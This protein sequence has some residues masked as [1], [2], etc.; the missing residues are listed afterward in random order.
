MVIR[1]CGNSF[2]IHLKPLSTKKCIEG[3][4]LSNENYIQALKHLKDRYGNPQLITL[5]HISKLLKLEKVFNRRS[6]K[7]LGNLYDRVENYIRSLLTAGI[8]QENYGPLLI[9]IV[10][11]NLP[12][13]I[14]LVLSRNL[15]TD[16]SKIDKMLKE[17]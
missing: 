7:E 6:V 10:L 14:K 5:T 16:K 13:D 11:G 3:I 15:G 9:P 17:E 2:M 4:T 8:L 12:D 1:A